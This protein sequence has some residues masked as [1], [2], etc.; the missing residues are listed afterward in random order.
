MLSP[1]PHRGKKQKEVEQEFVSYEELREL[2]IRPI[3]DIHREKVA[4]HK[5]IV[6]QDV[7]QRNYEAKVALLQLNNRKV[8][9]RLTELKR[10]FDNSVEHLKDSAYLID[11]YQQNDQAQAQKSQKELDRKQA[12]DLLEEYQQNE[13][14]LSRLAHEHRTKMGRRKR[15]ELINAASTTE[16]ELRC[17]RSPVGDSIYV[18][19][20][21][22][23]G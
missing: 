7:A 3:R 11:Q 20:T 22:V 18:G 5:Q 9:D 14:R 23:V 6:E 4:K 16:K 10:H 12:E 19:S 13:E 21:P 17:P 15:N 2:G 8:K 1:S